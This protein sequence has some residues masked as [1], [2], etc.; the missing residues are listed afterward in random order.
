MVSIRELKIEHALEFL[1]YV[2]RYEI[3]GTTLFLTKLEFQKKLQ[4]IRMATHWI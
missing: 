3:V 4:V 1:L 2:G